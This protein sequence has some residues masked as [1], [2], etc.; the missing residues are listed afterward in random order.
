M[1]LVFAVGLVV[2]GAQGGIPALCV[3]L[4]PTSVYATAVGLSVAC[5]RLGSIIGPLV[6]G[7]LVSIKLGSAELFLLVSLP[8]FAAAISMAALAATGQRNGK[9]PVPEIET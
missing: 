6:G 5:G 3:H 8:A 1:V 4:Y 9:D 7:Y 2:V